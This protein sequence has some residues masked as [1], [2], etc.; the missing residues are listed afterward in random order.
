M[1]RILVLGVGIVVVAA[2]AWGWYVAREPAL[3]PV[4]LPDLS[5]SDAPVRRQILD[6]HAVVSA[7]LATRAPRADR[8][9]AFGRLGMLLHAAEYLDAAEAA[10]RNAELLAPK[11]TRWTYFLGHVYRGRGDT[12]RAIEAFARV[13]E[14]QPADV[15]ALVWLGRL[16]LDA[17]QPDAAEPLFVRA[18]DRAP[19]A[20]AVL[21]GL[22]QV[23]L[24]RRDYAHAARLFEEALSIDSG[25]ASLYAPLAAAHRGLGD[26]DK[27]ETLQ[28][29]W[30]NTEVPLADPLLD[31]LATLLRSAAAYDARGVRALESGRYAEAAEIFRQGLALAS[32]ESPMARSMRHKR[33]LALHLAGDVSGAT[34]ELEAAIRLAP[35]TG[36]DEPA[37][38]AHYALAIITAAHGHDSRA[39]D[40][41]ARAVAYDERYVQAY[42]VLGDLERRRGRFEASLA[43]YRMAVDLDPMAAAARLGYGLA[44]VRLGRY[45]E[46]R[47]WFEE[48]VRAQPDRPELAHALA[49]LL[50]AAPDARARD[51]RRAMMIAAR[52][53]DA[54]QRTDY[55][56]TMAMALAE[57]GQYEQ[58][59]ALQREVLEAVVRA[60]LDGD[61]RRMRANLARYLRRQSCRTPW[62]VDDAI[63]RPGPPAPGL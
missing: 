13:V 61:V 21:A 19:R 10:Y 12:A 59:A 54:E 27:A 22:G 1:A 40:L 17:G 43:H 55:G 48:A 7:K 58:A 56:E 63:H 28:R 34:R 20:V 23:A 5:R 60:G 26:P 18:Q 35:A 9:E 39:I 49:R 14:R 51:G 37:A 24:A 36:R 46:A 62:P 52:L 53:L 6:Q 50:A 41:L 47:A 16:H 8:A 57:A 25:A 11:V 2:A 33:A 3:L 4:T 32:A 38:R 30:R 42:T 44:L 45:V 15:A 29:R 31:E